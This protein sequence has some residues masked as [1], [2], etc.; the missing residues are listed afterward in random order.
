MPTRERVHAQYR[1]GLLNIG[2]NNNIRVRNFRAFMQ[3]ENI[4]TAKTANY[5]SFFL[6]MGN[7]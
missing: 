2:T 4:F 3:Y 6:V 5:G 1:H 7:L